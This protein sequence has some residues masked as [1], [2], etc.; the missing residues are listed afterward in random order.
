M[1]IITRNCS[2]H[3]ILA[4]LSLLL[5]GVGIEH[6][7][8]WM[9]PTM[10]LALLSFT[11]VA[12]TNHAMVYACDVY[13]P[14]AG[15]VVVSILGYKGIIGFGLSFGTN[16]WIGNQG[17]QG[18]F[19]EQA[20][21]SAFF[22]LLSIPFTIWGGALRQASFRWKVTSWIQWDHDRD[23]LQVVIH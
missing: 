10:G 3:I 20:A 12:A 2:P 13:K 15:E 22:M 11:I 23:D 7:L 19:G 17:Y 9:C 21:I 6:G 5:Y 1:L 14:I 4:P 18:S 8:H 16:L